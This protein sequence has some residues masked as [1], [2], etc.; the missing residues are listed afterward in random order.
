[1]Y[2]FVKSNIFSLRTEPQNRLFVC[3]RTDVT[4]CIILI[5]YRIF[6]HTLDV[7][8]ILVTNDH[9]ILVGVVFRWTPRKR[10]LSSTNTYKCV[11]YFSIL[12]KFILFVYTLYSPCT[13]GLLCR[14]WPRG[15]GENSKRLRL[16][17][18]LK[19]KLQ[20][21]TYTLAERRCSRKKWRWKNAHNKIG[22]TRKRRENKILLLRF[23]ICVLYT[24]ATM[25]IHNT[26][27]ARNRC[28]IF[29]FSRSVSWSELR[30]KCKNV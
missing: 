7:K 18:S 6:M 14:V 2:T 22:V 26:H 27:A 20:K 12:G 23:T 29:I 11:L 30:L 3:I 25:H 10:N 15:K 21:K 13:G 1:M 5:D 16:C 17:L 28:E 8:R 19:K 24:Q 9:F 4:L